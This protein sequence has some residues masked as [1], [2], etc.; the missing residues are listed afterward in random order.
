MKEPAE[1]KRTK[2]ERKR[3]ECVLPPVARTS[4]Q[5]PPVARTSAQDAQHEDLK[6]TN[7]APVDTITVSWAL[8]QTN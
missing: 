8:D 3:R 5:L 4:A 2:V 6:R 7:G 1:Q